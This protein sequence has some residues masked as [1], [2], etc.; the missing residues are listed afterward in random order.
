MASK[1][2]DAESR[3]PTVTACRGCCC[4]TERAYPN[5]DHVAQ[6]ER[7]REAVKGHARLRVSECLGP[8]DRGNVLV[9]SPSAEGRRNGAR[10]VWLAHV[11]DNG[12]IDDVGHWVT[13]GGPGIGQPR[14]TIELY[15][16]EP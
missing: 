7:L 4:G 16:F 10:P 9:V 14:D 5:T 11:L 15:V 3:T 13:N 6:L 12:A 8:C 2:S 1:S